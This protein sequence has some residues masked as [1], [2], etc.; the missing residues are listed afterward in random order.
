MRSEV[1]APGASPAGIIRRYAG[2]CPVMPA[3]PA[4]PLWRRTS[5][6]WIEWDRFVA[7]HGR[8]PES[9][10]EYV[11]WSQQRQAELLRIAAECCR[12]R[13][14]RCGGFIVWMGHDCFPCTSNT[15][16]IDFHGRPKPAARALA[17]VF[18]RPGA[19]E[20]GS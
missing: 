17:E 13:F 6:W 7:E 12:R 8:E 14:P 2:D 3:T 11:E 9:L 15:A 16:I 20:E 1:G 5:V 18:L 4:N 19:P 10:E